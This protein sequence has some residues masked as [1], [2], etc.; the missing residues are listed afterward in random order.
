[1]TDCFAAV[2]ASVSCD[3]CETHIPEAREHGELVGGVLF[4]AVTDDNQWDIS[5]CSTWDE[6]D[7]D[8][9]AEHTGL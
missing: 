3:T 1:M 8:A 2:T 9:C 6:S 7:G 4:G 5:D